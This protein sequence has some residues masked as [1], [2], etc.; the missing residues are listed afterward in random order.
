MIYT[1]YPRSS[2]VIPYENYIGKR[3]VSD[4]LHLPA[5]NIE[6][7]YY[8]QLK[9][10]FIAYVILC[11]GWVETDDEKNV[12]L[13]LDKKEAENKAIEIKEQKRKKKEELLKLYPPKPEKERPT[14]DTCE[15]FD[16]YFEGLDVEKYEWE[17]EPYVVDL[18]MKEIPY[19]LASAQY[20]SNAK[21]FEIQ[22]PK[23]T[24]ADLAGQKFEISYATNMDSEKLFEV[25]CM[26][27][28]YK[29]PEYIS[30]FDYLHSCDEEQY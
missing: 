1:R 10:C 3:L 16:N 24:N 28:T 14:S 17:K 12:I 26:N 5:T 20:F 15:P 2:L 22:F 6:T 19:I 29:E 11:E 9:S 8:E 18:M 25:E 13:F 30:E 27:D 7:V 23:G 21:T 4:W